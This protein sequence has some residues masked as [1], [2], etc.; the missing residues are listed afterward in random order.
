MN[1]KLSN[2]YDLISNPFADPTIWVRILQTYLSSNHE[3]FYNSLISTEKVDELDRP[4]Y[5]N[6][7]YIHICMPFMSYRILNMKKDDR[8]LKSCQEEF[9]IYHKGISLKELFEINDLKS[10]VSFLRA[11]YLELR[12]KVGRACLYRDDKKLFEKYYRESNAT[13]RDIIIFDLFNLL[14]E[15]SSDG[16]SMGFHVNPNKIGEIDRPLEENE[17]KFYINAGV[18]TFRVAEMI[19][20]QC[21]KQSINYRFKVVNPLRAGDEVSRPDRLCIYMK[22][23]HAPIFYSMLNKIKNE[24]P[25]I[26]FLN[27]P[28]LTG[29]LCGFIGVGSDPENT[30]YNYLQCSILEKAVKKVFGDVSKSEIAIQVDLNPNKLREFREA[31]IGLQIENGFDPNKTCIPAN[32]IA[33]LKR[34]MIPSFDDDRMLG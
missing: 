32:R 4:K 11:N 24:H 19:W 27:P 7:F 34:I 5:L 21:I 18:D 10:L 23:E 6:E 16:D 12:E 14:T 13:E 15:T 20:Q 17:L 25:E 1:N 8:L 28:M 9:D 3:S 33:S 29:R 22:T 30:S 31:V 26:K 2:L